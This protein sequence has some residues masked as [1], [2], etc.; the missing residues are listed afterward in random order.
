MK[1]LNCS[2]YFIFVVVLSRSVGGWKCL[3]ASSNLILCR[4]GGVFL[5]ELHGPRVCFQVGICQVLSFS[6]VLPRLLNA[7]Q[8]YAPRGF[9]E[10]FWIRGLLQRLFKN[11]LSSFII[12]DCTTFCQRAKVHVRFRAGFVEFSG[13][14]FATSRNSFFGFLEFLKFAGTCSGESIARVVLLSS[15]FIS[16]NFHG[17]ITH[18]RSFSHFF[19]ANSLPVLINRSLGGN[20]RAVFRFIL[21]SRS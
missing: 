18:V 15:L 17:T 9:P 14:L 2:S 8:N 19:L 13:D 20:A 1:G 5:T 21:S 3:L 16:S 7:W 12:C 11:Y 6:T 4:Q 10:L